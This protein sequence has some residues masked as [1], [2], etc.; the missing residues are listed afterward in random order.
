[1]EK[2]SA[3]GPLAAAVAE[4]SG[5]GP[6]FAASTHD[7]GDVPVPPWRP[8]TELVDDPAVLR[9]RVTSV[10]GYLAEGGGRVAERVAA[11]VTHLGLVARL[12][13]PVLGLTVHTGRF[14]ALGLADVW[15]RPAL[16][17]AF[18]LSI[19][20][21]EHDDPARLITGAVRELGTAAGVFSVSERVLWG[22]VASAINGAATMVGTARPELAARAT[23]VA[24]DLLALPPLRHAGLR[25]PD[26][27]FQ[28]RS[29][30]LIY[31]ASPGNGRD[32]ICGDCVLRP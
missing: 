15:W 28:R 6:F 5:W 19:G 8:M 23:A 2:Q 9:E 3:F 11:S 10:R 17:G 21:V 26:G 7:T 20:P 24:S 30:C 32:A 13:S 1:M 18:P 29:C 27:R 4:V 25:H 16:G 12:V 22:N 14:P 31:R